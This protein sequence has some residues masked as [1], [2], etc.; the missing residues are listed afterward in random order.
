VYKSK[1]GLSVGI[2]SSRATGIIRTRSLRGVV[3]DYRTNGWHVGPF[4][5]AKWHV[6]GYGGYARCRS[7]SA[8]AEKPGG[9]VVI[10]LIR[11]DTC[12]FD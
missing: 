10:H 12:K 11:D 4:K 9:T 3:N 6:P 5:A 7:R 2:D 8:Y 1:T